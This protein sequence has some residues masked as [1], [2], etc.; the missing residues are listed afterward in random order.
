MAIG[1][2]S[3]LCDATRWDICIVY[4][5]LDVKQRRYDIPRIYFV[6]Y[7]RKS[8]IYLVLCFDICY[9]TC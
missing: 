3:M 5:G 6:T 8:A 2:H 7:S 1:H 4:H 9:V